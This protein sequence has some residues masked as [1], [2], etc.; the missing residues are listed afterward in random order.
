[1]NISKKVMSVALVFVMALSAVVTT[2]AVQ[3]GNVD[4]QNAKKGEEYEVYRVLDL[5]Y[6]K[7]TTTTPPKESYSYTIAPKFQGFFDE[8]LKEAFGIKAIVDN[9]SNAN[10]TIVYNKV[11]K[12]ARAVQNGDT[13]VIEENEMIVYESGVATSQA[14]FWCI[15]EQNHFDMTTLANKLAKY[16]TD[17]T[18]ARD[19]FVKCE[20]DNVARINGLPYGYYLMI[21]SGDHPSV[22]FSLNT[23]TP[24][25]TIENKSKY[26]TPTKTV[27]DADETVYKSTNTAAIGDTVDFKITGTV[28]KMTA[29]DTYKFVMTD[30][31]KNFSYVA[32]SAVLKIGSETVNKDS[33]KHTLDWNVE[34]K[35]LVLTIP[36]LKAFT[37]ATEGATIELTYSATIDDTAGLIIGGKGNENTVVFTYSDNPNKVEST[38]DSVGSKTTTF[39]HQLKIEKVNA[40]GQPIAGAEWKLEKKDENTF[41]EVST[42]EGK[43]TYTKEGQSYRY[44]GA[45]SDTFNETGFFTWTGLDAGTYRLTET[46]APAGHVLMEAPIEFAITSDGT[47]DPT[48]SDGSVQLTLK[49]ASTGDHP[50]VIARSADGATGVAY[51]KIQN[52]T[53]S[54]LPITGGAGL[55]IVA[56]VA[57]VALLGFGG[58]AMLKRKVNGGE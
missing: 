49:L 40:S 52:T 39:V 48:T 29:Y 46:E 30:T 45:Q 37:S 50:N 12:A 28:P 16:V 55:Y 47:L 19:S 34:N 51:M 44:N 18:L 32:G 33:D 43:P 20:V 1:M 4:I 17:N 14:V 54:A 58:T 38:T 8:N 3:T 41:H 22:W 7:D 5:D 42:G 11:T 10:A 9:T 26:P 57:I 13:P 6:A 56:G 31:M 2:H 21:P 35:T 25:A 15:K 23:V 36:N 53:Q 27:K 24:N